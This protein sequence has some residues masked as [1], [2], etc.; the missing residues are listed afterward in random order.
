MKKRTVKFVVGILVAVILFGV[1]T[2]LF[3]VP[4]TKTDKKVSD[5]SFTVGGIGADGKYEKRT[6]AVYTK[7]AINA[8]N[9]K[10]SPD[11]TYQG[12]YQVFYYDEEDNFLFKS[13][14]LTDYYDSTKLLYKGDTLYLY[15]RV[16]LLPTLE[17]GEKINFFTATKYSS[18]VT[19]ENSA[20]TYT[21][22]ENL[23]GSFKYNQELIKD[24]DYDGVDNLRWFEY[25]IYNLGKNTDVSLG[26][27]DYFVF[28]TPE[29]KGNICSDLQELGWRAD[30]QTGTLGNSNYNSETVWTCPGG[31]SVLDASSMNGNISNLRIPIPVDMTNYMEYK[32]YGVNVND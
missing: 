25:N 1:I 21:L 29:Y 32:V 26:D 11:Y 6:D 8:S 22:S 18:A 10:I 17:K 28:I 30:V 24:S 3:V 15:A 9:L 13:E 27:Y 12:Q 14:V 23:I 31:I 7:K 19:I 2:T 20:S 4:A 5:F 16:M